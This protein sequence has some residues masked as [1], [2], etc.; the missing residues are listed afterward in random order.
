MN[1]I[2]WLPPNFQGLNPYAPA[3]PAPPVQL[4]HEGLHQ[5]ARPAEPEFKPV[6]Q[7]TNPLHGESLPGLFDNLY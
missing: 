4:E 1:P 5:D 6:D 3:A 7:W 2:T